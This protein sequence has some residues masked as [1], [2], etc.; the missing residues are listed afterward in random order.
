M[1]CS[2]ITRMFF[3]QLRT[4]VIGTFVVA[5]TDIFSVAHGL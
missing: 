2:S 3:V 5:E 4:V 1:N